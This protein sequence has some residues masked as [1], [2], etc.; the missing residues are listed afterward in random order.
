MSNTIKSNHASRFRFL[1][2][3]LILSVSGSFALVGCGPINAHSAISQAKIALETAKGIRA[4]D[5]AIYEYRRAQIY[6]DKAKEEEGYSS[7]QKAVDYAM[8]SRDFSDKAR[9]LTAERSQEQRKQVIKA[10]VP[11]TPKP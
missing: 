8:M 9:A 5:Y 2:S 1:V 11:K 4:Q 7:F 6:Y 10:N 3:V